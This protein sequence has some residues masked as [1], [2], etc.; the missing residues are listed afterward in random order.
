MLISLLTALIIG[1]VNNGDPIY[2]QKSDIVSIDTSRHLLNLSNTGIEKMKK[3][4]RGN[5]IVWLNEQF[6]IEGQEDSYFP[7]FPIL[8]KSAQNPSQNFCFYH[9]GYLPL[10]KQEQIKAS[11]R[12]FIKELVP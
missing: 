4:E 8:T 9:L 11:I 7:P 5:I 10:E 6:L 3:S 1:L 2:L 12:T